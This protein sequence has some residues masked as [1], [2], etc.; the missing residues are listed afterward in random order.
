[1]KFEY[2]TAKILRMT[3]KLNQLA[4]KSRGCHI[5]KINIYTKKG[6]KIFNYLKEG[7]NEWKEIYYPSKFDL[8]LRK[9][10]K[11]SLKEYKQLTKKSIFPYENK[12]MFDIYPE[13]RNDI[14]IE[15]DELFMLIAYNDVYNSYDSLGYPNNSDKGEVVWEVKAVLKKLNKEEIEKLLI[16]LREKYIKREK[17]CPEDK[18]WIK[19]YAIEEAK[20][21]KEWFLRDFPNC[22]I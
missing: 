1:M 20:Y 16:K 3:G 13:T 21:R 8:T 15:F 10:V 19:D 18:K 5:D 14:K 2:N 4:L 17:N 6:K 12:K 7:L 11:V 9:M 22:L